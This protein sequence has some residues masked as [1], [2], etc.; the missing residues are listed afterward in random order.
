[1]LL[2][3]LL[4]GVPGYDDP[5]SNRESGYGRYDIR[6]AP[7]TEKVFAS[8]YGAPDRRPLVT[9]E[10]KYLAPR[11][12]LQDPD[13]LSAQL[14]ALAR[15]ALSQIAERAYDEGHLPQA[16]EGRLRWGFAFAGKHV[17]VACERA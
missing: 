12:A 11:D 5:Q 9:I 10:V 16:A 4:F 14:D 1:M 17:A 15:E 7:A 13:A 2:L 3:G 8:A 6:L